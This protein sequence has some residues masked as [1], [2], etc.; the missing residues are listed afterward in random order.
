MPDLHVVYLEPV[1][2]DVE[3]VV[4]ACLPQGLAL[5]VRGEREPVE[6]ALADA[7]FVLVATTLLP[8]AAIAAAPRLRLIQHQGVG[9][10][11]TDVAAA[12]ARGVPVALCPAG[13]SVG[14][15]EHVFLLI[16]ALYKQLL[17]ADASLRRGEWLQ[18]ALRANSYEIAGKCIG[19]VGLGRIGR[20]VAV[21]ARAFDASL[22]YYDPFRAS[23]AL[24]AELQ[25][26]WLPFEELLAQADL[27]SLH[28]PL[29][30]N[31]R[32]LINAT[33]L[34]HMRPSAVLI[35]T[36]RGPLVDQAALVDA[37][38][39]RQIAGAGLDVFE[40][41]PLRPDD[42]LLALP[43][44]VVTPHI[45]AG[46]VDALRAKMTAC[47]DNMLRVARG[48]PPHDIIQPTSA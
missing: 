27:V 10:D 28:L 31:T 9:Y 24:E 19:L 48:E 25:A 14:V 29:T 35:N 11:K 15:A 17:R 26:R 41:E 39:A 2:A 3:A 33:A 16:L 7:D 12:F 1:P 20:E 42:P 30:P 32:H 36:A 40:H 43:N 47:F 5:R 23:P 37:L 44:V 45:A 18:W 38:R 4:R 8:A 21:R 34:S 13:T 46:T 6:A 22:L